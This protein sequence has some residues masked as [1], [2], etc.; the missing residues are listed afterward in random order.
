MC[1]IGKTERE[2][3]ECFPSKAVNVSAVSRLHEMFSPRPPNRRDIS[4]WVLWGP[5]GTG[6][7]HR[8]RTQYPQ[9]C[10]LHGKYIERSSF[11][12][13]HGEDTL[14]LD[15]WASADWPYDV[16]LSITDVWTNVLQCRYHN[17]YA[18]WIRIIITTNEEPED[19]YRSR[20]DCSAFMR[21]LQNIIKV[22]SV[23]QDV[24]IS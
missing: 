2:I 19:W 10:V 16:M 6:K 17:K 11:D 4:T 8:A 15:D 5:T 24:V 12:T 23:E 18:Q 7:T 1:T 13:Y 21:R 14:I 20:M 22:E 9:A 3:L